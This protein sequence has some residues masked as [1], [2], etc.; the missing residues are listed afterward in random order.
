MPTLDEQKE[1]AEMF[2]KLDNQ[3]SFDKK[4]KQTLSDLFKTLLH[5]LMTGQR[6]LN[7]IDFHGQSSEYRIIEPTLSLAAE[8]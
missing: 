5:E 4:K 2:I 6:R 3:I 8:K 1:I 7:E